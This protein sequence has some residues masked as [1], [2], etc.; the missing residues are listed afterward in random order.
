MVPVENSTTIFQWL[1]SAPTSMYHSRY[2]PPPS[3]L[4]DL[5]STLPCIIST[6]F[7][8]VIFFFQQVIALGSSPPRNG[9][10]WWIRSDIYD[11]SP[12]LV[13]RWWQLGLGLQVLHIGKGLPLDVGDGDGL[14]G[15]GAAIM[16]L[17]VSD[18]NKAY[19]RSNPSKLN[20]TAFPFPTRMSRQR[21]YSCSIYQNK[22]RNMKPCKG[23]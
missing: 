13:H 5:G 9:P 8:L 14:V 21:T 1:P 6:T 22:E 23:R 11:S 2:I 20:T 3:H 16:T 4:L 17:L 7:Q 10:L 15:T 12:V 18:C 19:K